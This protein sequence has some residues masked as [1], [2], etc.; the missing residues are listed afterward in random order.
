MGGLEAEDQRAKGL[1]RPVEA[2]EID[3]I[4]LSAGDCMRFWTGNNILAARHRVHAVPSKPVS[5]SNGTDGVESE[6]KLP[7]RFSVAF[8]GQPDRSA[9]LA[10]LKSEWYSEKHSVTMNA[11]E[12]QLSRCA[13][14]Y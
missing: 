2:S 14:T 9:S 13:N 6:E 12:F 7:E 5:E 1:F 11:G 10:S 8:F 4:I 3:E